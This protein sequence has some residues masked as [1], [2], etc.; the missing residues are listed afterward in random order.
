MNPSPICCQQISLIAQEPSDE[1]HDAKERTD[2]SKL[3]Q[4]MKRTFQN[5]KL[6]TLMCFHLQ[7]EQRKANAGRAP[8]YSIREPMCGCFNRFLYL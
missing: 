2:D 5:R 1:Q 6:V 3:S 7:A 4:L 8:V